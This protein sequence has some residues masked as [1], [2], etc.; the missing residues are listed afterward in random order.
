MFGSVKTPHTHTP[1][2][3]DVFKY[4]TP[5]GSRVSVKP[6]VVV[7]L[8]VFLY[9]TYCSVAAMFD[10]NYICSIA[11]QGHRKGRQHVWHS[12]HPATIRL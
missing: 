1:C 5:S 11:S 9:Y 10:G 12:G 8:M 2:G 3:G 4:H 6:N 7:S